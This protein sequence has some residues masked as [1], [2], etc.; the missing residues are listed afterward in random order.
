MAIRE[1]KLTE[2]NSQR[3]DELSRQ[4]GK[5]P[6]ELINEAF[7][8]LLADNDAE[9]Q[10]KFEEWR[11]AA[12]RVAGIWKDRDDLPDFAELRK[13]WDRNPWSRA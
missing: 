9:E 12:R 3:L 7:A 6:E 13:S 1:I 10:R 4:S 2:Q 11:E 8:R 5:S